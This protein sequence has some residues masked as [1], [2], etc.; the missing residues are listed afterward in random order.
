MN[1]VLPDGSVKELAEGAT[2]ADV[3][4]SIGAGLAKAALAG[5]VNDQP[6]DLSAPVA[7]GD[8]VAIV[9]AKSDEGLELLRHSTAHVMAA[10]LVDLYGDVQFGVGPAIEDGFYYDVKT[11]RALSPDDFAAIEARMAEIVKA[12][13]PF[14]RRVV[15]RAEAEEIFANSRSSSSSS[16]SYRRTP[17]S[18]RTAS[19]VSPTSAAG[20]TCPPPAK[21][22]AFKLTKLAGAYWKGD[23]EREMLTRIY[24]TAFFKQKELDEHCATWRRPRSA[25]IASWVASW[26]ST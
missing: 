7:E 15:T 23:A 11:D 5:I 3:A 1:I 17:S 6:V 20:R 8:S 25:I 24:G 13:E 21:L 2:V 10:A 16:P 22:G 9:T 14:E 18:P 4:A 26:A 19:A 12:D